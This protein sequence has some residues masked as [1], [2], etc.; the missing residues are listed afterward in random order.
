MQRCSTLLS[1]L[2]LRPFN[3][4]RQSGKSGQ[5]F[6]CFRKGNTLRLLDELNQVTVGATAETVIEALL[7]VD[8]E[9]RCLLIMKRTKAGIFTTL[10]R[11]LGSASNQFRKADAI[12]KL[13]HEL[14]R[15]GHFYVQP[16]NLFNRL[17]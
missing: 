7:L 11:K 17:K 8:S 13:F 12:F 15:K 2:L 9:G 14:R 3:R 10:L 16:Y 1:R 4:H 5:P 6:Y